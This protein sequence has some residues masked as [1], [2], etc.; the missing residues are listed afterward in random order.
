MDGIS[1][2]VKKVL[3]VHQDSH[4]EVVKVQLQT[5]SKLEAIAGKV[6]AKLKLKFSEHAEAKRATSTNFLRINLSIRSTGDGLVSLL[7]HSKGIG[8]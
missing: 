5:I 7:C 3:A 8:V 2:S 6:G 1:R 4:A